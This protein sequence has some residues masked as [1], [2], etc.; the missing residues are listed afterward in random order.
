M[1]PTESAATVA[2]IYVDDTDAIRIGTWFLMVA[3]GLI[4][5]WG[6]GLAVLTR[7]IPGTSPVYTNLQLV[8]IAI[9]VMIGIGFPLCWAVASYRPGDVDPTSSACSRTSAGSSSC[10][11]GP[12]SAS[13]SW[14]SRSRSSRTLAS[15]PLF[16]R[17]TAYVSLWVC[18]L[19]VPAGLMLFFKTGAFAYNGLI[20]MYV[21][22]AVFFIWIVVMTVAGLR[23][24]RALEAAPSESPPLAAPLRSHS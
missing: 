1:H 12:R 20:A 4:A 22:L 24:L 9:G 16:P 6:V 8:C 19:S 10:S 23:A 5:P 13:G 3:V 21:P 2:Q 17:W 11:T 7:R 15:R 14:P 18:F